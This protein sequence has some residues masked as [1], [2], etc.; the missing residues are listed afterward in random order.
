MFNHKNIFFSGVMVYEDVH[1]GESERTEEVEIFVSQVEIR[2]DKMG[3]VS[4]DDEDE[5]C[6]IRQ[7]D[8]TIEEG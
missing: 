2:E 6:K 8:E 1:S 5:E 7:V 4:S 3:D